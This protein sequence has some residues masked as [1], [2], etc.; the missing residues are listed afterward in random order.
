MK[1]ALIITLIVNV[2][3]VGG[4]Y[5]ILNIKT[6]EVSDS[7]VYKYVYYDDAIPGTSY[8]LCLDKS[9]NIIYTRQPLCSTLECLEGKWYPTPEIHRFNLLIISMLSFV[10][11]GLVNFIK[12]RKK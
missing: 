10:I 8:E 6:N 4:L 5:I 2:L 3:I 1:K 11:V 7:C 9:L 12:S